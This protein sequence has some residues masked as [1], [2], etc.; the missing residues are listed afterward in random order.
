MQHGDEVTDPAH[1]AVDGAG[2]EVAAGEA[3]VV[4]GG[5][6]RGTSRQVEI[7]GEVLQ[8][9]SRNLNGIVAFLPVMGKNV[10]T[11][12]RA[13]QRGLAADQLDGGV[14][15]EVL[16]RAPTRATVRT[17]GKHLGADHRGALLY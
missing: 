14:G 7:E 1:V 17:M 8:R 15:N 4:A 6:A 2:C 3:G 5:A 10:H 13:Q 11:A 16:H 12:F 9:A